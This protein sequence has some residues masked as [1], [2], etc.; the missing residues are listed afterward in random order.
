MQ[1]I[2]SLTGVRA[3]MFAAW[4]Q[5]YSPEFASVNSMKKEEY[6]K[7]ITS[8]SDPLVLF[9]RHPLLE[10]LT[11]T[12]FY[13]PPLYWAAAIALGHAFLAPL[14]C[15][16]VV[17]GFLLWYPLEYELHRFLFHAEGRIP[18]LFH[19]IV[20][21]LH[22]RAPKDAGRLMFPPLASTALGL[23]IFGALLLVFEVPTAWSL[24]AGLIIG[25][26]NYELLHYAVHHHPGWPIVRKLANHHNLHHYSTAPCNYGVSLALFDVLFGTNKAAVR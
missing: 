7:Y 20:H 23:P 2:N 21:G 18:N 19:F 15:Y 6:V 16:L 4:L 11:H 14:S 10:A 9:P 24:M 8:H 1:R 25:Y 17:C 3:P 12:P 13:V 5:R 26:Q 22:H